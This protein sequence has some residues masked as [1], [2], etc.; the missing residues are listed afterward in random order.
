MKP[1]RRIGLTLCLPWLF[2]HV[3]AAPLQA[4][5]PKQVVPGAGA[6]FLGVHQFLLN[7]QVQLCENYGVAGNQP[8]RR[9]CYTQ[10]LNAHD[11][12]LKHAAHSVLPAEGWSMCSNEISSNLQFGAQ[13][14]AAEE[15]ICPVGTDGKFADFQT[16]YSVMGSAAWT[17]NPAAAIAF[18]APTRDP[19]E[20]QP[21]NQA[22]DAMLGFQSEAERMAQRAGIDVGTDDGPPE[23]WAR[24][25]SAGQQ[26][27]RAALASILVGCLNDRSSTSS[28]AALDVC[29]NRGLAALR[30][31][32]LSPSKTP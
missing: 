21:R 20:A 16:C 4:T 6:W 22:S 1:H 10:T 17:A 5:S 32:V 9:A 7:K 12:L 24:R 11:F 25:G 28:D 29:E 23:T 15:Q 3:V 19:R 18:D 26:A 30:T 31:T 8:M 13:C 14:I 2:A 27:N